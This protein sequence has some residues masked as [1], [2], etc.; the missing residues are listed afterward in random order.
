MNGLSMAFID[1]I[2]P[3]LEEKGPI[4]TGMGGGKIRL[5]QYLHQGACRG[6]IKTKEHPTIQIG[7]LAN[8][9]EKRPPI[10]QSSA[11]KRGQVFL[12]PIIGRLSRFEPI[13]LFNSPLHRRIAV[14]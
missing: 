5:P 13:K 9:R 4:R 2:Y 3:E 7:K 1:R 14:Y 11:L 10:R 6:A 8:F 12:P